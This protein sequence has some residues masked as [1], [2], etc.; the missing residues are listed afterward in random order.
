VLLEDDGRDGMI[1]RVWEGVERGK[2]G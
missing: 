2:V 1:K